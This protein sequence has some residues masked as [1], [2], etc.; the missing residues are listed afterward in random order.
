MQ[1]RQGKAGQGWPERIDVRF[2]EGR[3]L[4]S[5]LCRVIAYPE[6]PPSLN[7]LH[8]FNRER[9]RGAMH[10]VAQKLSFVCFLFSFLSTLK[11]HKT[12]SPMVNLFGGTMQQGQVQDGRG[13]SAGVME[14]TQE[15]QCMPICDPAAAVVICTASNSSC[16]L[17]NPQLVAAI[18]TAMPRYAMQ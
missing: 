3:A 4:P 10:D 9:P 6:L 8:P 15:G 14:S 1:A 12:A 11:S 13:A 17:A 16:L 2:T 18:C 5:L 7:Y